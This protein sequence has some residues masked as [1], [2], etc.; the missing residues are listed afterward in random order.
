MRAT[1]MSVA[2]ALSLVVPTAEAQRPGQPRVSG[3]TPVR[4]AKWALL[5][6]AAGFGAYALNHSRQGDEA[7]AA[8]RELCA[9]EQ[10]RCALS[11][12]RYEDATAEALYDRASAEDGRARMGLLGGQITLLGSAGLFIY[13]LRNGRGP[14]NIPYPGSARVGMPRGRGIVIGARLAF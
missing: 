14:E 3:W 11:G 8:L 1:V 10:S 6:V 7:Y 13:D 12:G 5:G 2:I 4:V 9:R